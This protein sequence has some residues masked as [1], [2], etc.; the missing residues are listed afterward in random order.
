MHNQSLITFKN[1]KRKENVTKLN[2][3]RTTRLN[4]LNVTSLKK[5]IK[6]QTL[7]ESDSTDHC[8]EGSAAPHKLR[9]NAPQFALQFLQPAFRS[10]TFQLVRSSVIHFFT[11]SFMPFKVNK[12][13]VSPPGVARKRM[14]IEISAEV[15]PF[16]W[17]R[18]QGSVYHCLDL[19]LRTVQA[20]LVTI[21]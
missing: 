18:K 14:N 9:L 16:T 20:L 3:R 6:K 13:P 12:E 15:V 10:F 21:F 5:L 1:N 11:I 4:H 17:L 2:Y 8:C 19:Q 7:N